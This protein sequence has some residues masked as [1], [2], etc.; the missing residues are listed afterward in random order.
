MRTFSTFFFST[1]IF[2]REFFVFSVLHGTKVVP[3][4]LGF[5]GTFHLEEVVSF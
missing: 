3:D 5:C 2:F 1:T 4:M